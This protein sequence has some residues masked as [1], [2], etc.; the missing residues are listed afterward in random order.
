[1]PADT[2]S[3]G[4]D[5]TPSQSADQDGVPMI[6]TLQGLLSPRSAP[7]SSTYSFKI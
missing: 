6:D 2:G 4:F 7:K 1:M 3:V 5:A